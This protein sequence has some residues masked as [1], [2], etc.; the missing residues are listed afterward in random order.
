M[1]KYIDAKCDNC[2]ST[3]ITYNK[4]TGLYRC[5]YCRSE[6][7]VDN[8]KEEAIKVA[9]GFGIGYAIFVGIIAVIIFGVIIFMFISISKSRTNI[10]NK[11][12]SFINNLQ[13]QMDNTTTTTTKATDP[14]HFNSSYEFYAGSSYTLFVENLL[15][16]VVT[17]N[18]TNK[19]HILTIIYKD[20]TTSNPEEIV[21]IKHSL[22]DNKEFEVSLDYNDDGYVYQI[23]IEEL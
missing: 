8:S 13:E 19:E 20:K 4:K 11:A 2:G 6:F 12:S 10:S 9:K 23:I 15:D 14:R 7:H 5:N 17:N 16:K 22:E 1:K 21:D 18:K 3:E